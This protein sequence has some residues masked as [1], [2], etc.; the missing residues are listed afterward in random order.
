M[1]INRF[2]FSP[3]PIKQTVSRRNS[4][5]ESATSSS[6]LDNASSAAPLG[7]GRNPKRLKL[8]QPG[9]RT[10]VSIDQRR[11]AGP[12]DLPRQSAS[13]S[14]G[15]PFNLS[16]L[17]GISMDKKSEFTC[18]HY[19]LLS[20]FHQDWTETH[21]SVKDAV[22][23]FFNAEP[24]DYVQGLIHDMGQLRDTPLDENHMNKQAPSLTSWTD[25]QGPDVEK[26][27]NEIR[28]AISTQAEKYK[29]N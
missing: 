1:P 10:V 16:R 12:I 21:T 27:L 3:H 6:S 15:F 29:N 26:L 23:S 18:L 7:V 9:L 17:G 5:E 24:D 28:D 13:F 14:E 2:F 11:S 4:T 8:G 22:A 19:L 25:Q 20:Y